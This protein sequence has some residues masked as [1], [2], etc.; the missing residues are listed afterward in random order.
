MKQYYIYL[1]TNYTN[2]VIYTG[3]TRDIVRRVYEHKNKL[4]KGFSSKYNVNK[5]VYFEAFD[6]IKEAIAREKQ[7]KAG[8]RQK[9][10]DLIIKNNSEYRD[11]YGEIV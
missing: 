7:I 1:M 4:V 11:L 9:K 2:N 6:N 8:P 3:V 10:I 5:L